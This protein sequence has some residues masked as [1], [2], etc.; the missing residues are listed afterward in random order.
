VQHD[1]VPVRGT[2]VMTLLEMQCTYV[3][4]L[5]TY[6]EMPL[7]ATPGARYAHIQGCPLPGWR[8]TAIAPPGPPYALSR[9]PPAVAPLK[10]LCLNFPVNYIANQLE[11][12]HSTNG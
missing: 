12:Q 9:R 2:Y 7:Q 5:T 1:N 8:G 3:M 6:Q 10:D 4:T 11:R